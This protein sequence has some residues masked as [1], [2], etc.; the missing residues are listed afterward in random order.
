MSIM[1][2]DRK[3]ASGTL[4]AMKN[5]THQTVRKAMLPCAA[6]LTSRAHVGLREGDVV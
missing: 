4:D 5:F 2:L 6:W 1:S 3:V